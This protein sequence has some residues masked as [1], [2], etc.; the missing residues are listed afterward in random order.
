M[1]GYN[2]GGGESVRVKLIREEEKCG[3][4]MGEGG[5]GKCEGKLERRESVK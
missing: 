5:R 2:G 4:V 3:G 1:W